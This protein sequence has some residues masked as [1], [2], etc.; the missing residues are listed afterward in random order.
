MN[1]VQT[2][3]KHEHVVHRWDGHLNDFKFHGRSQALRYTPRQCV[4]ASQILKWILP[5]IGGKTAHCDV[6][7]PPHHTTDGF[8]VHGVSPRKQRCDQSRAVARGESGHRPRS[9]RSPISGSLTRSAFCRNTWQCVE[10]PG[11]RR[12]ITRAIPS[13]ELSL[14]GMD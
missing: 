7:W 5:A 3:I 12:R 2:F 6:D 8:L 14:E 4:S 1:C 9:A 10:R 13:H 11:G